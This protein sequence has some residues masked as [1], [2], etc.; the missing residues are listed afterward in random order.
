MKVKANRK[1]IL[2]AA[3]RAMKVIRRSTGLCGL[4]ACFFLEV[5]SDHV[6]FHAYT[7]MA[8]LETCCE[9]TTADASFAFAFPF[10]PFVNALKTMR[11]ESVIMEYEQWQLKVRGGRVHLQIP[12]MDEKGWPK[13]DAF[14]DPDYEMSAEEL[15]PALQECNHALPEAETLDPI[16]RSYCI[17]QTEKGWKVTCLDGKRIS[18]RGDIHGSA[19]TQLLLNG[20]SLS[21]VL[22]VFESNVRLALKEDEAMLYDS[23]TR[24]YL[25][26]V[27]GNYYNVVGMIPKPEYTVTLSREEVMEAF[28]LACGV[29][30]NDP[31]HLVIDK[32]AIR[33][34]AS[35]DANLDCEIAAVYQGDLKKAVSTGL[36]P[37]YMLD[38]LKSM[39]EE[40]VT[41]QVSSRTVM[42]EEEHRMELLCVCKIR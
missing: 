17:E 10:G 3:E 23:R 9:G 21:S 5:E 27:E 29:L 36:N 13:H 30:K 25:R 22:N 24:V 33:I 37:R 26:T 14:G 18:I 16:I 19:K 35:G 34:Q 15:I 6:V 32:E 39:E 7:P 11:C 20:H 1:E 40:Q 31:A 8:Y 4:E 42:V 2:A 28:T 12:C 41:L 38:A